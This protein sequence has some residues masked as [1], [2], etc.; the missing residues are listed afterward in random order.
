MSICIE[1]GDAKTHVYN[2][3]DLLEHTFM[4]CYLALIHLDPHAKRKK[5]CSECPLYT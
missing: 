2:Q 4:Y 3:P 1:E 5:R